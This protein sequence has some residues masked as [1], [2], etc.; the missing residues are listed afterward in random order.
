ME[1]GA[2]EGG[3]VERAQQEHQ[4]AVHRVEQ[5]ERQRHR[6]P[7]GVFHLGPELFRIR[8]DGR[9]VF[10]QGELHA[11]VGVHVAVGGV[12]D[13]LAHRPAVGAVGRVELR[14]GQP[15]AGEPHAGWK[16]SQGR[17]R[18]AR[19]RPRRRRRGR[20]RGQQDTGGLPW[21]ADDRVVA[22]QPS[23]G[24][25][26]SSAL[27][28]C[29]DPDP[30]TRARQSSRGRAHLRRRRPLRVRHRR[31]GVRLAAPGTG[32]AVVRHG[33]RELRPRAAARHRRREGAAHPFGAHAG[34]GRHH[35]HPQL[36]ASRRPAAA[37]RC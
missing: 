29:H 15:G 24:R 25:N 33:G 8:L 20:R 17:E 9:V 21:C 12:V 32:R 34:Q 5:V 22:A 4:P 23:S 31:R 3:V 35:R 10:A 13:D 36:A 6:R 7:A 27:I 19:V 37:R 1:H 16:F 11:R 14:V 30:S 26:A 18:R 28:F 2:V